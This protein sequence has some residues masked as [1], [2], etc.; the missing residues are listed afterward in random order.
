MMKIAIAA[1]L[2][3][4]LGSC[5]INDLD[6]SETV[7]QLKKEAAGTEIR[8]SVEKGEEWAHIQGIGP[9][10]VWVY[11]QMVLWAEDSDGNY[12]ETLYISDADGKYN[13]H[14]GKQKMGAEFFRQCFPVW[15]SAFT[16]SGGSLPSKEAPFPDS[17]T[18]ATAQSSFRLDTRLESFDGPMRLYGEIN[19]SGDNNGTYHE[20]NNDW[21]GQPSI[22]YSVEIP[23]APA[24]GVFPM[25]PVGHGGL[26]ADAPR[27]YGDLSGIDSALE[28]V[29]GIEVSFP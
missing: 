5:L 27:I 2:L 11:P 28:I 1:V 23:S 10:R 19:K 17:L 4:I 9:F 26:I 14:A 6:D 3:C 20:G 24:P 8:I 7:I 22:I 13:R 18:S 16:G 15:A 25:R 29:A 12:I 21:A